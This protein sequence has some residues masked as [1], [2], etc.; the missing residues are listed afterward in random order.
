MAQ[1]HLRAKVISRKGGSSAP[2]AS[3]YRSGGVVK[4]SAVKAA[5]YRACEQ[6]RDGEGITH[7]YS[8]KSDVVHSEIMTPEHAPEWC[9]NRQEL[10]NTVEASEK[11]KDAQLAREVEVM[12]PR[13]L[14]DEQRLELVK[15]FVTKEFISRSMVADIAIHNHTAS[16]G[17]EH[18]HAH[19]MLT[20]RKVNAD[21]F[22]SKK[23][24][25]WNSKDMLK[26]WRKEWAEHTNAALKQHGHDARIDHRTLKAQGIDRAPQ[27]VRGKVGNALYRKEQEFTPSAHIAQHKRNDRIAQEMLKLGAAVA[28]SY[29][30]RLPPELGKYRTTEHPHTPIKQPLVHQNIHAIAHH[31]SKDFNAFDALFYHMAIQWNIY[32]INAL[33]KTVEP[34]LEPPE[35]GIEM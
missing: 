22:E 30:I 17:Q 26:H 9:K 19:I 4:G 2:E 16:D 5:A 21:G 31:G 7:N 1:Y 27:A 23:P 24:R 29:G 8:R 3:A 34:H 12:L 32:A 33:N 15:G 35:Q 14:N 20:M 13:E 18:P 28:Q 25:D 10:W 6:L 11:R